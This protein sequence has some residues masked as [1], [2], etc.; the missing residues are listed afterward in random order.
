MCEM[1]A[2]MIR[3]FESKIQV[4]VDVQQKTPKALESVAASLI[5]SLSNPQLF[6]S[7]SLHLVSSVA[8]APPLV[9][10]TYDDASLEHLG[11][12]HFDAVRSDRGGAITASVASRH[13]D[14]CRR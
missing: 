1:M 7:P 11:E 2:A 12:S 8:A 13:D 10:D 3:R 5:L 6:V 9:P 14:A 4:S